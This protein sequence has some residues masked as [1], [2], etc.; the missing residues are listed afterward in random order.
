[1]SSFKKQITIKC[2]Y[3]NSVNS[4]NSMNSMNSKCKVCGLSSVSSKSTITNIK[5]INISNIYVINLK[6]DNKRLIGFNNN[7]KKAKIDIKNRIWGRFDAIDG[8]NHELVKEVSKIF[9]NKDIE[10]LWKNY[11]GSIGC[12]LSHLKLWKNLQVNLQE[13]SKENGKENSKENGK[14]NSKD[15]YSLIMEDDAFFTPNGLNNL[16]IAF[17]Q[18]LNYDWDI[19]YVGHNILSG[20]TI[21]PLFVKPNSNLNKRGFNS[22]FFGYIIKHSSID[23]LLKI[24]SRFDS[25]FIDVQARIS[26]KEFNAL[27]IKGNLIKHVKNIS[28]RKIRDNTG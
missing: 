18:S 16:E 7:L 25:P 24:F 26:F 1:M 13:N 3:C 14:V 27:F 21:H 15:Y 2:E 10:P 9:T 23:K 19:L 4:M 17:R 28:S 6:K 11:K 20:K 12:Y 22:G 8:N 5:S